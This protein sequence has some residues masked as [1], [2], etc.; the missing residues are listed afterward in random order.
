MDVIAEFLN[1]RCTEQADEKEPLKTLYDAYR[2]WC[3]SACQDAVGKKM[4]G[5]LMK[6]KGYSQSKSGGVRYWNG[7]KLTSD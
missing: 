1:D 5:N 7:V 2:E 3:D 4:F 6:Q